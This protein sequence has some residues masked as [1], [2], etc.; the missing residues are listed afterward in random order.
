MSAKTKTETPPAKQDGR[1]VVKTI[2]PSEGELAA[3][4]FV[5]LFVPGTARTPEH[6]ANQAI[7]AARTFVEVY[8]NHH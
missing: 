1:A 3:Q 7:E 4:L 6:L 5:K 8:D 2:T